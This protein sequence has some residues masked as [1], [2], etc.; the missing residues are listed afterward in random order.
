MMEDD[1]LVADLKVKNKTRL[2]VSVS[3]PNGCRRMFNL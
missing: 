3:A 1:D 2:S